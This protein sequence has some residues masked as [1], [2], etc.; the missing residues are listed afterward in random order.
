L[1]QRVY[2]FIEAHEIVDEWQIF[3]IACHLRVCKC[4]GH[5]VT[6]ISP[7]RFFPVFVKAVSALKVTACLQIFS[8]IRLEI[9][10]SKEPIFNVNNNVRQV[11]LLYETILLETALGLH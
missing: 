9:Y 1:I 6:L 5:D 3:A 10:S 11:V 2:D 8:R 7:Q 4:S